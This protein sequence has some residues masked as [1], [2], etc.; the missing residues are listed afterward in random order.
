MIPKPTS[1]LSRRAL[2]K[3]MVV[4]GIGVPMAACVAP[5]LQAPTAV[6]ETGATDSNVLA[7]GSLP[8]VKERITLQIFCRG[9]RDFNVNAVTEWER[10]QTH[11][12]IQYTMGAG[13]EAREKLNLAI[14]AGDLPDVIRNFGMSLSDQ[15]VLAQ[16]NIIIALDDLI[17]Q[18][19]FWLLQA[20]KEQ[21]EMR[22]ECSLLDGKLYGIPTYGDVLHAQL[23]QKM[24]IYQPW[25][26]K[27]G[28]TMPTTTE[29]YYAVLKAF[30]TGDPNGNGQA[31]EIPLSGNNGNSGAAWN[32][33]LDCFLMQPFVF[34]DRRK[35]KSLMV[36][37]GAMKASYREPGWRE[38]L[39]YL[40]Q[41]F[42]EG[43]IDPTVFT[44]EVEH[45][46]ALGENPEP[47]LGSI[48]AA[49]LGSF[50]QVAGG[51]NRYQEYQPV[52]PLIG[53]T[54]LQQIPW[55]RNGRFGPGAYLITSACQHAEA[56]FGY[57]DFLLSFDAT[58]NNGFGMKGTDWRPAESG[59]IGLDG[60]PALFA[61]LRPWGSDPN[62][63][64]STAPMYQTSTIRLGVLDDPTAPMEKWLYEWSDQLYAP[65]G[66]VDKVLP[67]LA[68]T[69]EQ[70]KDISQLTP[71]LESYVDQAF[72]E[73]VT[74]KRNLDS[75]WDAYLTELD[76]LELSKFLS[77]YQDAYNAKYNV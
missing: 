44:N 11:I 33:T 75:D 18:H 25:L 19:G 42:A 49:T 67:L 23:S 62:T 50:T 37:D 71:V 12:D 63:Y 41:L 51:S 54:G 58:M 36:E 40:N 32:N 76:H 16:Q 24:F 4:A 13:A 47:R 14:A 61:M 74:G 65:Y 29:E 3:T 31:D 22:Q 45:S 6:S 59:E 53:P 9:N 73:F 69:A 5:M 43:L 46:Q 60:Q 28:L 72:A 26:D 20:F 10:E 57:G 15:Q 68:F 8:I 30:K 39:K 2:L 7:P 77:I 35:S 48:A 21:T 70:S 52:P 1:S 38:G 17:A 55:S 66:V 56:A 27:L 64:M 34:N